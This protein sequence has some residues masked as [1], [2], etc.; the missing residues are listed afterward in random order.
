[1]MRILESGRFRWMS[2]VILG[3]VLA[4]WPAVALG[5]EGSASVPPNS[6]PRP[7]VAPAPDAYR[8]L[9]D[10]L[11][12]MEQRLDQVTKQNE[13]LS[14]ENKGLG[15]QVQDL[16]RQ[17]RDPGRQG[18]VTG[19]GV[20]GTGM[21]GSG[22]G[23]PTAGGG[24]KTS[25]GDP[26]VTGRAQEV[27][28]RHRGKLSLKS[29]YDFDNDGFRWATQDD[30][31]T[32]GVRAM[33]QVDAR[34][35]QQPNQNPVSSGIYN[36]RTRI[37][38]EGRFTKPFTYEFSFQNF[39]DTVQL[40]D[41]YL[42]FSYDPRFQL[43]IGRY[44][45][46]FTYE[47]YR[48]HVWDLLA[49][50]RSLFANNYEGNR[51]FGLMGWGDLFDERLEYAVGTFGTQRNSF[52]TFDNRQDVMAFLNFKPF[53][54]KE[55]GSLLRDLHFGG[56]VD[57]GHEN[58]PTVPA[59]L[60]TNL[61]PSGAGVGTTTSTANTASVPFLA[62]NPGVNEQGPRALWELHAA[63]YYG[64]LTLLAAWESGFE[65]Y[66]KTGGSP[67]RI[68]INGWFAQAGYLL[69]GETIR[70]RTLIDP[71]RPFDLR[72]GHFG[73][74]AFEVTA[75]YSELDLNPRVFTAGLADPNLWT[76]RAEMTDVGFNWYPNK[77]VKVYFD[78]EHAMFAQPVYYRPGALQK[79]SDLFWLRFQVYF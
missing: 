27:G 71:L 35:Y 37:Y 21:P 40:L 14:R 45:T 22:E 4:D 38:F 9:L 60:R 68:P 28:N 49:P 51:R 69:T 48:I 36:P 5:Q 19:A 64:G 58:Q 66:A 11:G 39:F 74:G 70:D 26:T 8:E 15:D 7:A 78:W 46:P 16:S 53:Y 2:L 73:L 56:S 44:K 32:L 18:G 77:F 79:T 6:N 54:N 62:F 42:N 30:E 25:G 23:P 65:S 31:F 76:N 24:S 13:D 12:K 20:D 1:M 47:F 57:A 33:S 17:I 41:A 75:R 43:R 52:Q 55:E 67:T 63:Y 61:S 50:E 3:G 29:F 34:I 59:V 10:R 72:P